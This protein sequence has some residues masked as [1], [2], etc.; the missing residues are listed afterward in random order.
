M[1]VVYLPHGGGPWPF[2]QDSVLA[3]ARMYAKMTEYLEA[4]PSVA[5]TEPEAILVISAHWEEREPTVMSAP[6]PTMLYDYSGFPPETYE[7]VWP[8]PGCPE[9][10][11][12]II[13]LLEDAGIGC[14]ADGTRGFDHGVFVPLKVAYPEPFIP[15]VQLSLRGDLDPRAHV[16]MG[17][18][19]APL[20][21]RGVFMIGSGMSYHNMQQ[22]MGSIRRGPNTGEVIESSVV[23]DEWLCETA[24]LE[25]SAR[26]A[27]LID[28]EKAP[29]ARLAHPREEHLLPLHV[30][31]GAAE[32]DSA[33]LAYRD[34]ILGAQVSA[35]HFG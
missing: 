1:P 20:R 16:E 13:E 27:R 8:A 9:L 33:T 35:I 28:W 10:A 25:P 18:A 30:I 29:G 17:Q 4:L 22:L 12:A 3:N 31:A 34:V 14:A 32:D 11:L 26:R 6:S 24:M 15:T 19:L 7:I 2:M 5:P 21:E 23:F